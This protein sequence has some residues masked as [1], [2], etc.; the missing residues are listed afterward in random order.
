AKDQDYF[1]DGVVVEIVTALSRFRTLFVIA[2]GS[3]LSYRDA[4]IARLPAIA[5]ELGVRFLLEGSVRKAGDRV[6]IAVQLVDSH[7]GAREVWA[8]RFDD[9][10]QDLF[11]LQDR[12]ASAVASQIEP[13][14]LAIDTQ[15]ASARS[16]HDLTAYD[17][18]LQGRKAF[19]AMGKATHA[20]ALELFDQAIARD[21][22]Y[23]EALSI[24]AFARANRIVLGWSDDLEED[25]R[26]ALD[27]RGRALA[28]LSDDPEVLAT[29]A[30]TSMQMGV[31][32]AGAL[33]SAQRALARHPGSATVQMNSAWV[34]LYAGD[35]GA[36]LA[37]FE[38]S[39]RHDPRSPWRQIILFGMA[40]A[41]VFLHRFE[42]AVPL[43]QEAGELMPDLR[44]YCAGAIAAALGALGR[45]EAARAAMVGVDF[46]AQGAMLAGFAEQDRDTV[47]AGLNRVVADT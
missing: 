6:R 45:V 38:T 27:H 5:R 4:S 17:C 29:V 20:R 8:E 43:A 3:S 16:T 36:A 13:T 22:L 46:A 44:P 18:Y 19:G 35:A 7:D 31:D 25:R 37:G 30:M 12:V 1:C 34:F 28:A 15:R 2:S 32:K 39:L 47:L 23:A 9:T 42:A 11:A 40:F 14:I 10:L 41:N 26:V 24:S 33:A 21:P